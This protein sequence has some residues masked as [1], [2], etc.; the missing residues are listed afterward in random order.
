MRPFLKRQDLYCL[1]A[2]LLLC[3][4]FFGRL[5][6][7]GVTLYARDISHYYRPMH[8]LSAE[9]IQS[10]IFPFWNPYI[11]CGQPFFASLQHGLFYPISLITFLF[12]FETAFKFVF[13]IPFILAGLGIYLLLRG[14]RLPP[15]AG[16]AA[17]V[18]FCF[19]GVMNSLVNLLTT[20][21]AAVW[22]SFI[23]L[24]FIK[25]RAQ[26]QWFNWALLIAISLTLEF[27]AGQPEI[28]YFSLLVLLVFGLLTDPRQYGTVVKILGTTVVLLVLFILCEL[29]PFWQLLKLSS[30]ETFR[31]WESQTYWSLYPGQ[32]LDI[33]STWFNRPEAANNQEWLRNIFFGG[34][35]VF[36]AGYGLFSGKLKKPWVA[37]L[38]ITVLGLL[39]SF[40]KY[41]FFYRAMLVVF[42]GLKAI[43]YPVKYYLLFNWGMALLAAAGWY[44]WFQTGADKQNCARI[45]WFVS[46]MIFITAGAILIGGYKLMSWPVIFFDLG[47]LAVFLG[48]LCWFRFPSR[49]QGYGQAGLIAILFYGTAV[50][51][52]DTEKLVPL[53]LI[54]DRGTFKQQ[55]DT[56]SYD[57]YAFTPKTY[58]VLTGVTRDTKSIAEKYKTN[59]RSLWESVPN[60][61]MIG[62][63]FVARGYESI[64]LNNFYSFY[65]LISFQYTPGSSQIMNLL[66]VKYLVSFWPISD[67][68]FALVKQNV[69]QMYVN[70][71]V[72]PRVFLTN[73]QAQALDLLSAMHKMKEDIVYKTTARIIKYGLNEVVIDAASDD[74]SILV[75]TDTYYPGWRATI[76]GQETAIFPAYYLLRGVRVPPGNHTIVFNYRPD[77]F[78]WAALITVCAYISCL[79]YCSR[80]IVRK[81]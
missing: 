69:W 23:C 7:A 55:L 42:P 29:L 75:L 33:I 77:N 74:D 49:W 54:K 31:T 11:S 1:W 63:E 57:R 64:Y 61:A 52:Y 19:G 70:K 35:G 15:F 17:A 6:F 58:A 40:G 12:P 43:R 36:L 18:L 67:P 50:H 38:V 66:G 72:F 9:S 80:G 46:G 37:I 56:L 79:F 25:A 28:V 14:C 78:W 65:N 51:T 68:N 3:S 16:L 13:V 8:F 53:R 30:R 5:L 41:T 81:D 71:T 73:D 62:H 34:S 27:F 76:D 44:Q 59:D 10:G 47:I 4:I 60:M 2:L 22:L 32:L 26:S 39:L 45:P 24:F 21:T 20:L 48:G